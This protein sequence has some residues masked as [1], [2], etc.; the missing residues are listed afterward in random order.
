MKRAG[1]KIELAWLFI[2]F[3]AK[4][5]KKQRKKESKS[6][7]KTE[8]NRQARQTD[9]QDR[10]TDRQDRQTDRQP[11]GPLLSHAVAARCVFFIWGLRASIGEKSTNHSVFVCDESPVCREAKY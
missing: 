10:Q 4:Q 7:E 8:T 3:V 2:T 11:R 5:K 6:N 9:R 1:I